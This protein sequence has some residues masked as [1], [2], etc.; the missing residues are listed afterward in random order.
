VTGGGELDEWVAEN[1]NKHDNKQYIA[2]LYQTIT[3]TNITNIQLRIIKIIEMFVGT[4]I[5]FLSNF[6]RIYWTT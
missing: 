1:I 3:V 6:K 4:H 5:P 2:Q